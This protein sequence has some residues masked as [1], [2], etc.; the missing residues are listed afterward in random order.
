MD[1]TSVVSIIKVDTLMVSLRY[2]LL[3]V[4]LTYDGK[5]QTVEAFPTNFSMINRR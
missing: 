4:G 5:Q 2:Y 3:N 1:H